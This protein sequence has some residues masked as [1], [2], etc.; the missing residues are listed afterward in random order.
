MTKLFDLEKR[1]IRLEAMLEAK[2]D[3]IEI[4]KTVLA[5]QQQPTYVGTTEWAKTWTSDGV[6][7]NVSICS[8]MVDT[9]DYTFDTSW[10]ASCGGNTVGISSKP[11][12]S[13]NTAAVQNNPMKSVFSEEATKDF[14]ALHG[15]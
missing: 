7:Y 13:Q 14:K 5:G 12:G 9:K 8:G 3:L 4:L 10:Q 1:I 11:T 6:P 15:V 2:E